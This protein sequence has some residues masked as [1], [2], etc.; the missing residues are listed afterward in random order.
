MEL[1]V[2]M[3][4]GL[5]L[6]LKMMILI[7]HYLYQAYL[8]TQIQFII[9]HEFANLISYVGPDSMLVPDALPD[10]VEEH[11]RNNYSRK[12]HANRSKF[13]LGRKF[14][15]I[16]YWRGILDKDKRRY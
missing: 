3:H 14:E 7:S 12:S 16:L 11:V 9:L 10:E 8:L 1:N 2:K 6:I 15:S 5:K 4:I 13:R